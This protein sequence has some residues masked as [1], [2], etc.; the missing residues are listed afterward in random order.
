MNINDSSTETVE[1]RLSPF[2]QRQQE[3]QIGKTKEVPESFEILW[4]KT[5]GMNLCTGGESNPG[6]SVMRG[7]SRYLKDA[8]TMHGRR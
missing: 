8:R 6:S 7:R 5:R 2:L 4:T 3:K 1:V